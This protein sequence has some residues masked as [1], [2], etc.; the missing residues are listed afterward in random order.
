[1][2]GRGAIATP[3][4]HR[5]FVTAFRQPADVSSSRT[6]AWRK[7]SLWPLGGAPKIKRV[8]VG[9]C[10]FLGARPGR[11]FAPLATTAIFVDR[12]W[13]PW[14]VNDGR[15]FFWCACCVLLC[16]NGCVNFCDVTVTHHIGR[17]PP[18]PL[19]RC[20]PFRGEKGKNICSAMPSRT[21]LLFSRLGNLQFEVR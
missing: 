11:A 13:F 19:G 20:P 9:G 17:K 8:V 2:V 12:T 7:D 1:M 16:V 18:A 15:S 4:C 10:S 14:S 5:R 21:M 3:R 6:R